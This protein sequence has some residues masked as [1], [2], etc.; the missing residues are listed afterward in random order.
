[1]E[2]NLIEKWNFTEMIKDENHFSENIELINQEH[3]FD[4]LINEKVYYNQNVNYINY[5]INNIELFYSFIFTT[6][7][8]LKW[9]IK[10]KPSKQNIII[11]YFISLIIRYKLFAIYIWMDSIQI[12][13]FIINILKTDKL[14][15][16]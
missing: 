16:V 9:I 5:I 8:I 10:D 11:S 1:M 2:D 7:F 6:I 12:V 3:G 15:I 13:C 14:K 4:N